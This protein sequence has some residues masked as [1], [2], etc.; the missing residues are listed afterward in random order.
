M[1]SNTMQAAADIST[2]HFFMLQ[3][4]VVCKMVSVTDSYYISIFSQAKKFRTKCKQPNF[5]ML[6][7]TYFIEVSYR[8]FMSILKREGSKQTASEIEITNSVE[9]HH[10]KLDDIHLDKLH[11]RQNDRTL[12]NQPFQKQPPPLGNTSL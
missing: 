10:L 5:V 7:G 1:A 12:T 11:N 9:V 2:L 4:I 3:I 8:C 6:Q